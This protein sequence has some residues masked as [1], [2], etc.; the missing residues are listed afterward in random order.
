LKKERTIYSSVG[1]GVRGKLAGNYVWGKAKRVKKEGGGNV[2]SLALP[3]NRK[4]KNCEKKRVLGP[5]EARGGLL[6]KKGRD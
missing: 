4:K 2:G 3:P 1:E 5:G 6:L